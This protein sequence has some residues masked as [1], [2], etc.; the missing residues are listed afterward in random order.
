MSIFRRITSFFNIQPGE[1]RLVGL[2]ALLY[3]TMA[4]GFVF[5]QSMAFGVFIAEYG[6]Q[7]LP[8]SYISI[9]FLASLVA[10]LYIKISG[11]ISF[12]HL[13]YL[14]LAFLGIVSLLI[15]L[16][17]NSPFSHNTAFLLPLWF[18]VVANQGNL[19]VW[20]LAGR[21]FDF[22]Q[23]KRLFPLLGAG[24]WLGNIIGGLLVPSLVSFMGAT[25]LLVL[26]AAS[27]GTSLFVVRAISRS[28]LQQ[29]STGPQSR[30]PARPGRRARRS[31]C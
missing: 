13:L 17:L 1:E 9:A 11:R 21:L 23:G 10:W 29:S 19:A 28:Y 25:N 14:N 12:S 20:S 4:L 31:W 3:F 5:V 30:R 7:G 6:S 27:F 24:L 16:G 26:A 15:W 2:L 18:Q 8:Y 22:R